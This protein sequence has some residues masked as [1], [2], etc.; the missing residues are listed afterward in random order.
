MSEFLSSFRKRRSPAQAG[1]VSEVVL[2]LEETGEGRAVLKILN[3]K[4]QEVLP[5][6]RRFQGALFSL[7]RC[8]YAIRSEMGRRVSWGGLSSDLLLDE[9]PQLMRHL[10]ECPELLDKD[11]EPLKVLQG[12]YSLRLELLQEGNRF[13]PVWD[14]VPQ[15][16]KSLP[17][18]KVFRLLTDSYAVTDSHELVELMPIG[19][20]YHLLKDLKQDVPREQVE[21]FLS[22]VLSSYD[23]IRMDSCEW[24]DT[25]ESTRPTL[26]FEKVDEEKSLYLR[27]TESVPGISMQFLED[28]SP[29]VLVRF[30]PGGSLRARKVSYSDTSA[31]V[32]D[33]LKCIAACSPSRQSAREVYQED[34]FFILPP[35]VA[36]SFLIGHLASLSKD[37]VL[38]GA[39]K[40]C[41]F[42]IRK[43]TPQLKISTF[44]GIDYLEGKGEVELEGTSL[45]LSDFLSQY[46]QNRYIQIA[47]GERLIVD[48]D[49]VS[50]LERLVSRGTKG[51]KIKISF[52]DLPE[53][54]ALL[55]EVPDQGIFKRSRAFYEGFNALPGRRF[56]NPTTLQADLRPYQKEGVKWLQYLYD[57]EMGGCLADDMGLGK[58]VETIAL[59]T[60]ILKEGG[61]PVLIVMPRSLLFNWQAEW[62]RFAPDIS[63]GTYY[64]TDRDWDAVRRAQV[65]LTTYAIVRNDIEVLSA[66]EFDTVILDESQ[67]VKNLSA[68]MAQAVLLLK[69]DHHFALSG[70]PVE[71]N[72]GELFA[73][74]RFLNP[75]MLG[76]AEEFNR[77]YAVPIQHD[78]DREAMEQLRRKI[79]PFILRRL[80]GE[81]LSELPD[82]ID[83]MLIVE[84][85][86]EHAAFYERRRR[87]YA[88][89]VGMAVREKGVKGAQFELLQALTELR[90]IASVPESLSDGAIASS[91][92]PVLADAV[93]EAVENGH[94][95][96][97]FF[98][99]IAGIELLGNVLGDAGV[100]FEVM[101]GATRDRAAVVGRFQ[102]D[103]RCKV[104]LMTLKT[105]GVGL[106]LTAA[107]TVFVA[108]PW[109]NRSAEEQA[110]GR[111]HRIG[112]KS[113]VHTFA[114]VTKDTI[115]EKIRQLQEQKASLIEE[116]IQSEGAG[117]KFL[118]EE[119]ISF[120]L[121]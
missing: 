60:R 110:I 106:N 55:S 62:K 79:A 92:I 76:S 86:A 89:A 13:I 63:V 2:R 5:D 42:Q 73:L 6:Y 7:L 95:C 9:H 44:S 100:D 121:G 83:Q 56:R 116:L 49:Y 78:G 104:L 29:S 75:A 11:G 57:N 68:K 99:F 48:A 4:G 71:N 38:L 16:D 19:E 12:I 101:T 20:N 109:W 74:M 118:S 32:K 40:L 113:S 33:M 61:L 120:I 31:L 97:V 105:G 103:P 67:H 90:R 18:F 69:A 88:E 117:G 10:V 22:V 28:F 58:T 35:D 72:L 26:V 64:G 102:G 91:K 93:L 107:D 119:D 46:R 112:Q 84:M 47:G 21:L 77:R 54:A 81:V 53:V 111:L 43:T 14:L 82:R 85:E 39:D 36:E 23:N 27:V 52:F 30:T 66:A 15:Q 96:V 25:P 65:I 24:E 98:N 34:G 80:K 17:V 87:Y 1:S 37:Y 115:E 108:E 51:G 45:S 50:R 94:K 70:T 8:V 59:I 41:A 3:E 114:L